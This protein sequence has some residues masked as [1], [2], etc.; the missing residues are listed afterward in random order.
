[1][2]SLTFR[3]DAGTASARQIDPA[4]VQ[5]TTGV[6]RSSAAENV[7]QGAVAGA[8]FCAEHQSSRDH[9]AGRLALTP[10]LSGSRARKT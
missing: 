7:E 2:T 1:M 5:Q 8:F 3:P 10:F 4:Q 6:N 9:L